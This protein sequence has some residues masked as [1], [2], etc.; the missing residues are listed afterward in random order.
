MPGQGKDCNLNSYAS[1]ANSFWGKL[2]L[3]Y[4]HYYA[5]RYQLRQELYT[6]KLLYIFI[7]MEN[8]SN[9]G[10]SPIIMHSMNCMEIVPHDT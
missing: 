4:T 2:L 8:L 10:V 6:P 5:G 1:Q 7:Y 3:F 9:K